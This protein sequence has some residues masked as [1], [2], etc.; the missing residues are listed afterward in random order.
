MTHVHTRIYR[1][2]KK[3]TAANLVRAVLA[4]SL[5]VTLVRRR[6]AL[7]AGAALELEGVTLIARSRRHCNTSTN[8]RLK[9]C[10][11][12]RHYRYKC[13]MSCTTT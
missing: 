6:D 11:K 13:H 3:P 9:L 1:L 8:S 4:V 7:V 2:S 10:L 12:Q 5:L